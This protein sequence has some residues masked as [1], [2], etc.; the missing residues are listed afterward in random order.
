MDLM[1]SGS[2]WKSIVY[3]IAGDDKKDFVTLAFGW[4]SIVGN[5][6]AERTQLHKIEKDVLFVSVANSVWMQELILRKEQIRKDI[7]SILRIKLAEIVFFVGKEDKK[8]RI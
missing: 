2:A 7:H 5:I 6:L 3:R 1:R 8:I 4:K